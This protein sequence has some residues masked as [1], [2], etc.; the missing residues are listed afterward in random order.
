MVA[1]LLAIWDFLVA[2][3][4]W[5]IA[6][7]GVLIDWALKLGE[8][9]KSLA[10]LAIIATALELIFDPNGRQRV[11]NLVYNLV[12]GGVHI[13]TKALND[14]APELEEIVKAFTSSFKNIAPTLTGI[15]G[16]PIG[17]LARANFANASAGLTIGG[18]ST[19]ANALDQAALAFQQTFGFGMSSAA[20][21][22]AFEALFPEKLNVLNGA[23]PAFA[24]MAGFK[25]VAAHVL[26]P[27]YE[28]A[29]GTALRY[30][31]RGLFKPEFANE[32]DAVKWHSRRLMSD[33]DLREVFGV[34]GLKAK[35][36]A[37][38]VASAYRPVPPFLL[39]RAA[40]A[41]ALPQDQLKETL[42][43]AGFRDIDIARLETAYAALALQPYERVYLST[44]ERAVE[45]GYETP[46]YLQNVMNTLN[47]NAEM[48]NLV[49]LTVAERRADNLTVL[50]KKSISE[51]YK[52]GQVSDANYVSSLEAVGIDSAEAEALYSVDSIA[53]Q[54]KAA[55]AGQRAA[56]RLAAAQTRAAMQA[57][58]AEFRIGSID[59][60]ELEAALIAAGVDPQIASFAV[61][62]QEARKTGPKVFVYGVELSR[63]AA[64]QIREKVAALA[65]QSTARLITYDEALAQLHALGIPDANALALTA[66]W[67]ATTTTPARVGVREPI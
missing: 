57:A 14:S 28:N 61:V 1:A 46:L 4:P 6:A 65:K 20:V 47:L 52:Y 35:Y 42:Q 15:I 8:A 5:L 60:V 10:A 25:E 7:G 48:Q 38:F 66:A 55:I 45:L 34:S 12:A 33:A 41:G 54:G 64:L 51:A 43:F 36:E 53:K 19:P 22:A 39:A 31:Y 11:G 63:G 62:V 37:A 44:A 50:Y 49:Q 21:T 67:F 16:P 2:W 23:G 59:Q 32:E 27:L 30:H 17:E 58:I 18:E 40:E 9:A 56:T 13:A 24:E 29:F 26:D 3:G